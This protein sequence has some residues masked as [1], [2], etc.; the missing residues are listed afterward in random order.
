VSRSLGWSFGI[1]PFFRPNAIGKSRQELANEENMQHNIKF[2]RDLQA[3]HPP[4][5]VSPRVLRQVDSARTAMRV[6]MKVG[7]LKLA[8]IAHKL[9]ISEGYL[10]RLING[11]RAMPEWFPAGF[12]WATECSLLERF[13]E[14]ESALQEQ[15]CV[16]TVERRI[17]EQLHEWRA[18]A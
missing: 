3:I 17:A 2:F 4:R 10:S 15:P 18:A 13:L 12:C 16:R 11:K 5:D 8:V 9:R 6:S 1:G 14:L 7:G